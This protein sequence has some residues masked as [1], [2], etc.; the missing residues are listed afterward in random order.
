MSQFP[1]R[2]CGTGLLRYPNIPEIFES[3]RGPKMHSAL[4]DSS[5]SLE[6]KR[7]GVVGSGTSAVQIIPSIAGQVESLISFQRSPSWVFP[8]FSHKH[9]KWLQWTFQ[10]L[11]GTR[12]LYRW[13]EFL[14]L[15]IHY[16][17]FRTD[18]LSSKLCNLLL[19]A[20]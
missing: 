14:S 12:K 7:V 6:G 15:E 17:L 20:S 13:K 3:F 18:T 11:P 16:P 8:R 5:V 2:I 1:H 9:P 4:W 19:K 10:H